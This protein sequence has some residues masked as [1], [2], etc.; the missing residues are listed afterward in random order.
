MKYT[1]FFLVMIFFLFGCKETVDPLDQNKL[2]ASVI[3]ENP[4]CKNNNSLTLKIADTPDT[5]SCIEYSYDV[6]KKQLLLT[7]INAAFNCCPLGIDAEAVLN[8]DSIVVN[9]QEKMGEEACDCICLYDL[10]IMIENVSLQRYYFKIN[11]ES[12]IFE[13]FLTKEVDGYYCVTKKEYPW[14]MSLTR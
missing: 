5:L 8:G 11:D 9:E 3:N 1:L 13:L 7:H 12:L 14:G 4:T 2:T 10:D 6:N